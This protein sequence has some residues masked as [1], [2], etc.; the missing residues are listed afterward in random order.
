MIHQ[1]RLDGLS[2]LGAGYRYD[3]TRVALFLERTN[4]QV[5]QHLHVLLRLQLF[6]LKVLLA[7]LLHIVQR[8]QLVKFLAAAIRNLP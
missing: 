2:D 1:D 8:Y 5:Q 6:V 4:H 3:A 7:T